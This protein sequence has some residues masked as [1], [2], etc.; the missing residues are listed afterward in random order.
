MFA[1]EAMLASARQHEPAAFA[2][3]ADA[4]GNARHRAVGGQRAIVRFDALIA[5]E[6]SARSRVDHSYATDGW[7]FM[8][9]VYFRHFVFGLS[10][11]FAAVIAL[12]DAPAPETTDPWL[13]DLGTLETGLAR[14][15]ANFEDNLRERSTDL[16][17]I[18]RQA[19]ASLAAARD[20]TARRAAL[21]AVVDAFRDPHLRI[22]WD[23]GGHDD[24]PIA[25]PVDV[26]ARQD[27]GGL[28]FDRLDGYAPLE[29]EHG[30]DFRAGVYRRPGTRTRYGILRIG[31]FTEAAFGRLCVA[32]AQAAGIEPDRPCDDACAT[33]LE[34]AVGSR[35]NDALVRVLDELR[36]AGA[37]RIVVDVTDN[38]GGSDWVEAV[39][40]IVGGP[41]RPER[42]GMLRHA[43][44]RQYV[45]EKLVETD[46]QI[47][48]SADSERPRLAALR[49]AMAA[50]RAALADDCDLSRAWTDRDLALGNTPLPCSTIVV[51]SLHSVG[52]LPPAAVR[53]EGDAASGA[54]QLVERRYGAYR[55]RK[56]GVP[57][58][59]LV[60]ENTHSAAELFAAVLQDAKRA[61][62]AGMPSPGAGCGH[63][64]RA[65]T[66]FALPH[67]GATVGTPDCVRL[68]ADG[69]S[70]RRGVVPDVF[71]PWAP[72]DSAYQRAQK[73]AAAL[74]ALDRRP[75][76][77]R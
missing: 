8:L 74:E 22:D 63:Y 37:Q 60:N 42:V 76:R 34:Q 67:A 20:D 23:G 25:C 72:S 61:T 1:F 54:R 40:R 49:T 15:Y 5:A 47:S 46:A 24:A 68:R 69:S 44:W 14:S 62:I 21:A 28:R 50:D 75:R 26:R 4:V 52:F 16:T 3:E 58:V 70:E 53:R 29:S 10:A 55:E 12:A 65:G 17:A 64:T 77:S 56:L 6:S 9:K 30:R 31:L 35:L 71:V 11:A 19:R 48:T 57:I 41:L 51:G 59:V 39:A 18:D 45:D 13:A 32:G 2:A 43:A 36:A 7:N 33:K 66:S 38:S 27:G 73:A